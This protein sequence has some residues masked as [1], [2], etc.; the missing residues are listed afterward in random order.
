MVVVLRYSVGEQ[1]LLLALIEDTLC[2]ADHGNKGPICTKLC[3]Y[4]MSI[5]RHDYVAISEMK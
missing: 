2:S 3:H 1:V 4:K 5:L